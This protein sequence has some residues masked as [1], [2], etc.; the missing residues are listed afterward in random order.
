MKKQKV[1][2]PYKMYCGI[3]KSVIKKYEKERNIDKTV[4]NGLLI[5]RMILLEKHIGVR[6]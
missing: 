6:S 1:K 4:Y 5:N 3:K 2:M